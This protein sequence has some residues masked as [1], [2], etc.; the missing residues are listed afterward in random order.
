MIGSHS[1]IGLQLVFLIIDTNND[2]KEPK[3]LIVKTKTTRMKLVPNTN[4]YIFLITE[5]ERKIETEFLEKYGIFLNN[6]NDTP[7]NKIIE[8]PPPIHKF[9]DI[10]QKSKKEINKLNYLQAKEIVDK[11]GDNPKSGGTK[12]KKKSKKTNKK[13]KKPKKVKKKIPNKN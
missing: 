8:F 7:E 4:P 1:G 9:D 3:L 2:I 12:R 6:I 13:T 10:L 11:W 5:R